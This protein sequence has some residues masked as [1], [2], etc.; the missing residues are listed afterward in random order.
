MSSFAS[1]PISC[2]AACF[3]APRRA[4]RPGN[5]F[6]TSSKTL[7][8]R[9]LM[10]LR[11]ASAN[12]GSLTNSSKRPNGMRRNRSVFTIDSSRELAKMQR[13][14]GV[15]DRVVH[16]FGFFFQWPRRVCVEMQTALGEAEAPPQGCRR[17][18]VRQRRSA[19]EGGPVGGRALEAVH[20]P[21]TSW[22]MDLD[23]RRKKAAELRGREGRRAPFI[24]GIEVRRGRT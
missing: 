3:F 4:A 20:R 2:A 19:R 16:F 6:M 11:S 8:S 24:G 17:D 12:S 9:L 10:S 22:V 5:R 21:M 15:V 23:Q 7:G 1:Y 14:T 18:G 13:S